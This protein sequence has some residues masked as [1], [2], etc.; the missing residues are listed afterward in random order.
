VTC[1]RPMPRRRP[2]ALR[3]EAALYDCSRQIPPLKIRG[4]SDRTAWAVHLAESA[5]KDYYL[6]P[7][8]TA[9]A[10]DRY[11]E[12]LGTPKRRPLKQE[13]N[14]CN[15]RGC[16]FD[17]V[18]LAR[19]VLEHVIQVVPGRARAEL[20]GTVAGMDAEYRERTVLNPF[21]R[22]VHGRLW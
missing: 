12:F 7:G 15:C 9:R 18:T 19:E 5:D 11:R 4:L 10:L 8:A 21:P 22:K 14:V 6:S 2:G 3:A 20:R 13:E 17:D 1:E 16:A